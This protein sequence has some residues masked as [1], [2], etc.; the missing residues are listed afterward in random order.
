MEGRRSAIPKTGFNKAPTVQ[1]PPAGP[2]LSS[3]RCPRLCP[4]IPRKSRPP[5]VRSACR[6]PA[7]KR[8]PA[9]RLHRTRTPPPR[10]GS[11]EPTVDLRLGAA[12]RAPLV[13]IGAADLNW[14]IRMA[15]LIRSFVMP[16][17]RPILQL[18]RLMW[19]VLVARAGQTSDQR[20]E[21]TVPRAI[22]RR[23]T[24]R[25][26]RLVMPSLKPCGTRTRPPPLR[27][28]IL[29]LLADIG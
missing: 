1:R 23:G 13:G 3:V 7:Q 8:R 9:Y 15:T 26:G 17:N 20:S 28:I 14:S 5:P 21:P 22:R 27:K 25:Q 4:A 24:G 10:R 16:E 2:L 19:D 11:V 12:Q 29:A 6:D 18:H